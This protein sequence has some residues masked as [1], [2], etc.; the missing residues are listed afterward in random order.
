[1]RLPF[2]SLRRF[3]RAAHVTGDRAWRQ[4][5]HRAATAASTGAGG[6]RRTGAPPHGGYDDV[7][8]VEELDDPESS[9]D[10]DVLCDPDCVA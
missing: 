7:E 10:P 2:P 1:M 5:G 8:D 9:V 6:A 4:R 3:A